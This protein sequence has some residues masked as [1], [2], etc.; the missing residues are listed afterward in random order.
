MKKVLITGGGSGLGKALAEVYGKKNYHIILVGR[1]EYKLKIAVDDLK[2]KEISCEYLLCD[3]SENNQINELFKNI[4]DKYN[5]I[6]YLINNAGVGYFGPLNH[7]TLEEIDN[8]F[9]VNVKGTILMT[10]KFIAITQ[11]RVLNIIST[12]GLRGKVNESV[13]AAS[14][15]AV[16]GFTESIQK[17]F[18]H[19]DLRITAVY[20]GGMDT[21]F[22]DESTHIADKS[23]LR[24][25]IEVAKEIEA[26]DDG[27]EE[28]LIGK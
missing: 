23:R 2:N 4:K 22:W 18:S 16:R 10:Q 19:L 17:E 27:R 28:I 6:D 21:P 9:D 26:N 14:K 13:Y 24:S 5:N 11:E 20:M 25:P 3:I 12:A 15:F 7:S 8:M 1:T